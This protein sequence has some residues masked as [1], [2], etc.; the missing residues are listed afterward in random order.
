MIRPAGLTRTPKGV[1]EAY[2]V[3]Q[4]EVNQQV[5]G[6][7][8][9]SDCFCNSEV[10]QDDPF[11]H[12][13]PEVYEFIYQAVQD[14]LNSREAFVVESNT[15][16]MAYNEEDAR[17]RHALMVDCDEVVFETKKGTA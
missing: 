6:F 17:R 11:W 8:V 2:C 1:T 14:K 3:M 7:Q 15:V 12:S 13:D 16:L 10:K 9:A 4:A 5:F